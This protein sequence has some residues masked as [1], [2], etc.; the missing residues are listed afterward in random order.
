MEQI[1][2]LL[3]DRPMGLSSLSI[4]LQASKYLVKSYLEQLEDQRIIA[5]RNRIWKIIES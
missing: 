4:E 3:K 2:Y 1:L 5:R